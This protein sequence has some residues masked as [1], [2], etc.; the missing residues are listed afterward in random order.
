MASRSAG[1]AMT[2][3]SERR[4]YGDLV[5]QYLEL[6]DQHPGIILLFRIGTF[7]EAL[8]EDAELVSDALGLKLSD[9]PSGG[10]A[11]PVPQCGFTHHALDSYLPRLLAQG[12]RVAVCEEGEGEGEGPRPR[13]V[14]RTLTPGTVTDPRL[15]REDRPTYLVA[16]A[17]HEGRPGVAWTD[18]AAGEFKA[19]E[20]DLEE[21]AAEIQRLDPAEILVPSDAAVPEALLANRMVT[22]VGSSQGAPGRLRRA[23]PGAELADL[24]RAEAAAGLIVGYLEDTRTVDEAPPLEIPQAAG[25]DDSMRL[26]AATQRHLELV[27]TERGHERKGSLLDAIDLTS[28]PMG[29]RML[30]S[31]LLRPLTDLG[32]IGVRQR[33]ISELVE[34][35]ALRGELRAQLQAIADVERL[36]GRAASRKT[37]L[38]DLRALAGV[39][40]QLATLGAATARS[41]S[42][43]VRALARERPALTA[44]AARADAVLAP[45]ESAESIRPE[46][47]AELTAAIAARHAATTWQARYVE[48]LRRQPGLA[49]LK[50]ERTNTQGLF[51]EVPANTGVPKDWIRRGGLA[52]VERYTTAE[53]EAH[54]AELA[55]AEATI[56]VETRILLAELRDAAARAAAEARDLARRLAA[57][58]VLAALAEVAHRRG[59]VLP[60]IDTESVLQIEAG[61]H[62]VLEREVTAFQPNDAHLEARGA[63]D[64][65]VVLTGPNMAGKSTW[66]RQVALIALL[67]QVGSFVP[68]RRAQIGI[69]DAIFTRI[70]AVDDLAAGRSTFMVEMLET[71]TVLQSATDR[72]LVILDEIGRGTSTHDGMAIAWAVVEHLAGGP[73][74]P[75]AITATHYHE[76]AA[77]HD[78][79][80]QVTLLQAAVE[81]RQ[82]GIVFPHRI[83]TGAAGRSFGP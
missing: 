53:L 2:T 68:A 78:V 26:D 73:V 42:S 39:A 75:R 67:A 54:A 9:R 1:H 12:Y 36:A 49:K 20:F 34:D 17:M 46:A 43:F 10:S 28:T 37:S 55:E 65:L 56:V 47:S 82:D 70:G 77:L 50:L 35:E 40:P 83:V 60:T 19:G 48:Q 13:A 63:R 57:T 61:R 51:L 45:P 29:R 79:Y 62:P 30:R 69:V 18:V 16:I 15:L 38:D 7:Y 8:F 3:G 23:F 66:M 59:W 11:P 76:L 27:E 22:R 81:E 80:A 74:R 25:A 41:R 71:A 58:D 24:P 33:I 21:A 5:R 14:V 31:W 64:Q 4:Q 44:F 32:K 6:R 52:K 72:S